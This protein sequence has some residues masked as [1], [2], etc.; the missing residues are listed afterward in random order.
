[1]RGFAARVASLL[2][3]GVERNRARA[4]GVLAAAVARAGIIV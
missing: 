4:C 3:A 2:S 1:M